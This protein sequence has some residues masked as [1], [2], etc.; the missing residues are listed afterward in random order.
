MDLL[1]SVGSLEYA[2]GYAIRAHTLS[3]VVN[4]AMT[5][6]PKAMHRRYRSTTSKH[7]RFPVLSCYLLPRAYSEI[8]NCTWNLCG[9]EW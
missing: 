6:Y 8:R 5:E 3:I 4:Q 1:S 7:V 9:N 2:S